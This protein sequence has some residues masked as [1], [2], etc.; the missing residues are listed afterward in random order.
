VQIVFRNGGSVAFDQCL[1]SFDALA[2]AIEQK[3][4][5]LLRPQK[6]AELEAQGEAGFGPVTFRRDGIHLRRKF[7][8]WT[9]VSSCDIV[10]GRLVLYVQPR[11]AKGR[12]DDEILL[13][14]VPNY[15]LLLELL[16]SRQVLS[17]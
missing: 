16:K 13:S 7:Y 8:P 12:W 11:R 4:G 14:D 15:P 3:T 17:S 1:S 2:K 10:N 5:E 6:G 9:G